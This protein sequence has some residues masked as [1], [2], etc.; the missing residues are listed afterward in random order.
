M[1]IGGGV[2]QLEGESY[3]LLKLSPPISTEKSLNPNPLKHLLATYF[4]F[5]ADFISA[6]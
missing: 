4:L 1:P 2:D 6:I 5:I 3:I